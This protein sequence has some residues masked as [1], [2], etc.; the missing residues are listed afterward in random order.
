MFLYNNVLCIVLNGMR[1]DGLPDMR[2]MKKKKTQ[3]TQL[4]F[5]IFFFVYL[6]FQLAN[7]NKICAENTQISEYCKH[8]LFLRIHPRHDLFFQFQLIVRRYLL[9][10]E[11]NQ[12]IVCCVLCCNHCNHCSPLILKLK[13]QHNWMDKF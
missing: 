3:T 11:K 5:E 2:W 6:E 4:N 9:Q 10:E 12:S 13:L 1:N 7:N 8:I